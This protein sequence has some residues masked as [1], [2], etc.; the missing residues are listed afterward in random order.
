MRPERATPE[1][2]PSR[3]WR[4]DS[5][6]PRPHLRYSVDMLPIRPVLVAAAFFASALPLSAAAQGREAPQEAEDT[7]PQRTRVALG[8]ALQPRFPGSDK[9]TFRPFVDLSR[10]RGDDLFIFEAP[11]ENAAI[12]LIGTGGFSA[13][14]SIAFQGSRRRR[15]TDGLLPRVGSSVEVGG[16]AQVQLA[17]AL[18]LRGEARKGIGGHDGLIGEVSADY[19]ARDGDKWLFSIGPRVTLSD[20]RYQRAYFGVRPQDAVPAGLTAFRPGGGLQAVGGT[21]GALFQL[22]ERWGVTGFVRYD[23]L[24]DDAGRSP[25]VRRF[26][27]RDQYSGGIAATFTFG[28]SR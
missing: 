15:D 3:G 27:S 4:S 13:G 23:R 7:R 17:P 25:V 19:V 24:V 5:V 2:A 11:D 22:T 10:A 1:S 14:P 8:P 20:G 18:R 26:G 6:T 28:G 12:G 16:F 9:V 21:A